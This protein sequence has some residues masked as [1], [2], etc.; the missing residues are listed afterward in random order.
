MQRKQYGLHHFTLPL[1]RQDAGL[2]EDGNLLVVGS[3]A[4]LEGSSTLHV[5]LV[6]Q[7]WGRS[8]GRWQ[9]FKS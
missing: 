4:N 1:T 3:A 5:V 6:R 8:G 2:S 9:G 7:G